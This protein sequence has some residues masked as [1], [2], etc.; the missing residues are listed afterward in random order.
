M[1]T[2][3]TKQ[4]LVVECQKYVNLRLQRIHDVI[5]GI[6]E[7]LTSETKSSAGDKHETGRAM[8]QLEREKAGKQLA[9]VQK[10]QEIIKK[11]DISSVSNHVHLGSL[12]QTS[13]GTYFIS[14]SIGELKIDNNSYFAIAANTP[15][16][17]V[18]L[19][20]KPND[21]VLFNNKKMTIK[22]VS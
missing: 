2:H 12:V 13:N 1:N 5:S 8:L 16:G 3:K 20:K 18:L 17:K 15:I 4:K 6:Q 21:T 11:I 9:Q 7:S 14:I 22:E 19:G 10:L